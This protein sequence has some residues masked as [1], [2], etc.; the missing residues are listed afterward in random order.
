[1]V[2][3][4]R[5]ARI[6][7]FLVPF[8]MAAQTPPL[9]QD[10]D[11]S[12][13][14]ALLNTPISSASKHAE[15][16]I[17][18]PSVVSVAVRDQVDAYG[19][20]SLNDLL[21]TLPGFSASQDYDR[22]T[23][24]SRGLF[25][26][27][28]N[29]HL[30]MQVDGIPFNDNIY[31][32]ALTWEITPVF[33]AN[34]VE[35]VRGP[36]SALYGSNA[37]NGVIQMKTVSAGDL[38][39]GCVAEVRLGQDNLR[40]YDFVVGNQ[41]EFVSSV[42]GF[43]EFTSAG[44][45]YAGCDGSART[46]ASGAL[47]KFSIDDGRNSQYGWAKL[48]GE[49]ALKGLA[50]QYHWQAWGFET[51]HGWLWQVPDLGEKMREQRQ[52]ASLSY[53]SDFG[54]G[55]HQE[56]LWRH[57]IHD[58][59]WNMRFYPSVAGSAYP[60]GASEQLTTGAYDDFL[61]T[62]WSV[63]LPQGSSLLFGFEGDRF[64]Y[65]GDT[66]HDS[67][68]NLDTFAPNP[69][70]AFLPQGPWLAWIQ[71]RPVVSTGFYAQYDSGKALGEGI[72]T[73]LGLRSDRMA[74]NYN[75]LDANQQ[76]TGAQ[77]AKSFSNVSPRVAVVLMPTNDLAIKVMGGKA[78]R[79]PAPS[80]L[81]GA[82]T[83]SLGSNITTL[84][85]ET[86]TTFEGAVN[87]NVNP[88][89]SWNT[90]VFW[91]KFENEIAY[92]ALNNNL[93]T[94]V[95]TLTTEGLESEV[96]F[97][98]GPWKGFANLSYARRVNETILDTTIAPSKDLTWVPALMEKFGVIYASGAFTG[99]LSGANT[100]KVLRRSTDVGSQPLPL[101]GTVL[102]MDTYRPTEVA[103]YFSLNTKLTYAFTKGFSVS[104]AGTN[105]TDKTYYMAKTLAF[106]FD[107]QGAGRNISL[108]LKVRI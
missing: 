91:T 58:I 80:E 5:A 2:K 33:L 59:D 73:V 79:S 93:S 56:Y 50:F 103:P 46:D 88:H 15:R 89:M 83:L 7:L 106:P 24:S 47:R 108:I 76:P 105:L 94:N 101:Q 41:G 71:N 52:I 6:T 70:N 40:M 67:N 54:A 82:N 16:A 28:N 68:L 38:P 85:P 35:V 65:S 25:E 20:K 66:T 13:L 84:K 57:Q 49:G 19:W 87:W 34:T 23:V 18:A 31:G 64:L 60:Q 102:D 37:M 75:N 8:A 43:Q 27:W 78:F 45:S 97:G 48:E 36:G 1:M 4:F 32:S 99:S 29:N 10:A 107:Y 61:R 104:L 53:T 77:T 11:A 26:G 12:E 21:Y 72:K 42:V 17:E 74:F 90:N 100:G 63:D 14:L 95:Y 86:L 3:E 55:W 62:Q 51:G 98:Y 22:S 81:A 92:S 96:L 69:G 39:H 44:N 9:P 30:L